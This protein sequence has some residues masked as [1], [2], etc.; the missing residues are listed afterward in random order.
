MVNLADYRGTGD[1]PL[2]Y[3]VAGWQATGNQRG[4]DSPAFVDTNLKTPARKRRRSYSAAT[5]GIR[6]RQLVSQILHLRNSDT[7]E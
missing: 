2:G 6:T 1:R 5:V 4:I 3:G 7:G